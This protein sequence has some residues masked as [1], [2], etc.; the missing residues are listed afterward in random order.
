MPES[1]SGIL[2]RT[3]NRAVLVNP[4]TPMQGQVAV[5]PR[6][7]QQFALVHGATLSGPV[8]QGRNGRELSDVDTV[9]GVSPEAYRSRPQFEDLTAIDP[10][11]RFELGLS[12]D[13]GMRAVELL[14]PIGKGTRGLIVAPPKAGKTTLMEQ[15]ARAIR[16][17]EPNARIVVLLIDERPEELTYFRRA[18]SAE[19]FAS[20][21]DQSPAEHTALNE[22]MLAHIR[23]ELECGNEVVVLLDSLTRLTRAYN[24]SGPSTGSGRSAQR[25]M[26][27]GIDAAAMLMPRKFLGLARKIENGGSV[28]IVAS[29]LIDTGSR[30]DQFIYEEFKSTGNS[31]IVL[32]R[33]LAQARVFPAIDV[34]RTGTRKEERLYD[35]AEYAGLIALRRILARYPAQE[36]LPRLLELLEEYPTNAELLR[37]LAPTGPMQSIGRASPPRLAPGARSTGPVRPTPADQSLEPAAPTAPSARKEEAAR[38]A[39]PTRKTTT[40]QPEAAP[41]KLKKSKTPRPPKLVR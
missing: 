34:P 5:P 12:G 2:K 17:Q 40:E 20:S 26:S 3:G 36:A 14:A 32:N 33:D 11:E 4:V 35:A 1:A 23:T 15:L 24:L 22:L 8:L 21:S 16:L 39:R 25:T 28:T 19:V 10:F 38:P 9:C 6:L 27:G 31:E 30:M 18:V 7:V 29:V 41:L 37:G 13:P